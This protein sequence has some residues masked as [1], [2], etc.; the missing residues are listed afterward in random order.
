M[1]SGLFLRKALQGTLQRS[2]RGAERDADIALAVRAE[3][4]AG[5]EKHVLIVEQPVGQRLG[6]CF[7]VGDASPEEESGLLL[8][9]IHI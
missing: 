2:H 4:A 9:L 6:S 5:G 1:I 8:S 7:R 3:D